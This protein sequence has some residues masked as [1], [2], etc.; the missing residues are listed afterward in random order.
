MS[1]N[2]FKEE[3]QMNLISSPTL[4]PTLHNTKPKFTWG[5]YIHKTIAVR[6]RTEKQADLFL[7]LCHINNVPYIS[8]FV[9]DVY[10]SNTCYECDEERGWYSDY[11][12]FFNEC[13]IIYDF[14]E[15]DFENIGKTIK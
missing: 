9:W 2:N 6:C 10:K 4:T 5:N 14:S 3:F 15:I 12:Y 13:Y 1:I 8:T 11:D 7:K